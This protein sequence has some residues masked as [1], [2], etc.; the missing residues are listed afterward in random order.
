MARGK[1]A[2]RTM[3][4]PKRGSASGGGGDDS[5]RWL[6]TYSDM[7]TL[8]LAFFVILF[9][10]SQVDVE[11]FKQFLRGL[12]SSFGNPAY[13]NSLLDGAP[14]IVGDG[15]EGTEPDDE[16][17][18]REDEIAVSIEGLEDTAEQLQEALAEAGM[19]GVIDF[20][21]DHRGLVLTIGTDAVL[22]STG[23]TTL[24]DRG[25]AII[26]AIAPIMGEVPND[27]KV[28]GH[29][30]NVP[31]SRASYTNWNLSTDRAV[32]VLNLLWLDHSIDPSRLVA[33]GYGEFRPR[34]SNDTDQGRAMNRRV[35]IIIA[36]PGERNGSSSSSP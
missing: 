21:L 23:S 27:I 18:S 25:R 30:D 28:E 34:A 17:M 36:V 14:S 20:E 24:S 3:H 33:S 26:A 12:E 1:A 7:V 5:Q 15:F 32:A 35:E 4:G 22:F 11:S 29:T 6:A 9:S 31:L 19:E 16:P 2:G 13:S 10:L 8:V